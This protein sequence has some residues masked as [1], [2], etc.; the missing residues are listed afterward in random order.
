MLSKS[1]GLTKFDPS[2]GQEFMEEEYIMF[3]L[4]ETGN[5]RLPQEE[6]EE[7]QVLYVSAIMLKC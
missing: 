3:D 6:V 2:S 1:F 4:Y 7:H 5:W